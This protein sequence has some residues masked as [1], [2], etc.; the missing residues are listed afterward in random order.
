MFIDIHSHMCR[1]PTFPYHGKLRATPEKLI[2]F[3]DWHEIERGVL[4]PLIGP[5]CSLPQSNEDILEAAE[6]YPGRFIPFCNIH[7]QA[8]TNDPHAP[9]E[10]LLEHY[11]Q[12][13]CK[14]VG[15][16]TF[17]MS[18]FDPLMQNYFR[19]VEKSGLPLTFHLA[20]RLGGCYGIYDD[21]GLPGLEET[22]RRFPKLRMFGHSQTFWAEIGELETVSDRRGYPRGKIEKEGAV[23]KLFRRCPNLF[24]DLSAGSGANALMRDPEYAV[25]FLNEFQD[26]LCFGMD[27]SL[28]PAENNAKLAKFLTGLLEEGKISETVFRKVA[29]EN[30]IK[31]LCLES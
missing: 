29:R 19:A 1:R 15:E 12:Y 7:P 18:F 2:E 25:R 5:E 22:L 27:I 3:Y 24:G 17:N 30:A 9:L 23:P 6:K 16:A 4:L 20:H 14:G 13:G 31:I 10:D 8:L 11:K 28:E 21:P 26:R